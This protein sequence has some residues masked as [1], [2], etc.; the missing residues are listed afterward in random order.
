MEVK[1]IKNVTKRCRDLYQRGDKAASQKNF[2]FAVEM[3]REALKIEPAFNDAREKLRKCQLLATNNGQI[4]GLKKLIYS[5]TAGAKLGKVSKMLKNKEYKEALDVVEE[6]LSKNPADPK[7]AKTLVKAGRDAQIPYV[8]HDGLKLIRRFDPENINNLKAIAAFCKA[9]KLV[10]EMIEAHETICKLRPQD[11]EAAS[12]MKAAT[13]FA[14]MNRDNWENA[15]SYRDIIKDK[16]KAQELEQQ[17]M[18]QARDME[19]LQSLIDSTEAKV[20]END[21]LT[22]RKRLAELYAQ[23]EMWE[24]A[25]LNYE[26]VV[27]FAGTAEPTIAAAI[28]ECKGYVFDAK[29]AEADEATAA[30]LT[31]EKEQMLFDHAESMVKRFPNDPAYRFDF[32]VALFQRDE[33]TKSLSELQQSQRNPRFKAKAGILMGQCFYKRG[34][35]DMAID[36][37]NATLADLKVMSEDKKETLYNLAIALEDQGKGEEAVVALKEVFQADVSFRDVDAR[38]NA[39]YDNK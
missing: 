3:Y 6:A 34:Q 37:Y 16:D 21:N 39:Y 20:A 11:S 13:A 28:A 32:G 24:G 33:F 12:E 18:T 19:T 38:I 36:Q 9:H 29:I 14:A 25:L 8:E 35:L 22:D 4:G 30:Q 1:T 2:P 17:E 15:N 7:A 27:E 31:A 5:F 23:G 10:D 26:K